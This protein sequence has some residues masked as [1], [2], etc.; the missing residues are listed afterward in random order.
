MSVLQSSLFTAEGIDDATRQRLENCALGGNQTLTHIAHGQ[1]GEHVRRVQEALSRIGKAEQTL[2]LPPFVVSGEYDRAFAQAVAV[3][4]RKRGIFNVRGQIDDI[5]GVQ[6]I[7]R[8]DKDLRGLSPAPQPQPSSLGFVCG[9]DVTNDIVE[10]W[11]TIQ[12]DFRART[13]V[14]QEQQCNAILFPIQKPGEPLFFPKSIDEFKQLARRFASIDDWDVLPLFQGTSQWLRTPPIFDAATQG[15]CASPSSKN[16]GAPPLDDAHEDP[17]TCSD[18][19]QVAGRCWLN[20]TVNY[21]TF[22]IM[23]KLCVEAKSTNPVIM[24]SMLTPVVGPIMNFAYSLEWAK[25]LIKSYKKFGGHPEDAALP[26]AWT[27]ATFNDGPKGVPKAGDARYEKCRCA[28]RCKGDVV[29][30]DYVWEPVKTRHDAKK[31]KTLKS[32]CP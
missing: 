6:T 24:A 10:I 21:G 13:F 16:P 15:P 28:C 8:L 27:E 32:S 25:T 31:P 5:V 18:T 23:V 12:K 29:S 7:A 11:T 19:V 20:G 26:V 1:R 30:W 14:Q 3:Y 22:G 2:A 17:S 9:P 4:K